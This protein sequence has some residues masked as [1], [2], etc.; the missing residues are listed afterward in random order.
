MTRIDVEIPAALQPLAG[1]A[2]RLELAGNQVGE[3]LTAL[4]DRHRDVGRRILTRSGE[5]RQHVNVFLDE[6]DVRAL[7]GL[8]TP[9]AGYR[10]MLIVPSVAGG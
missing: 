8:A 5:L 7:Q 3:V 2:D 1:G 10:R 6:D 4:A 9:I